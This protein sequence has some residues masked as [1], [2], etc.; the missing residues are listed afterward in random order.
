M[1]GS[2]LIPPL[3]LHGEE[4]SF[5]P[6]LVPTNDMVSSESVVLIKPGDSGV[7][8]GYQVDEFTCTWSAEWFVAHS[9][10][11]PWFT[12]KMSSLTHFSLEPGYEDYS[13]LDQSV[14]DFEQGLDSILTDSIKTLELDTSFDKPGTVTSSVSSGFLSSVSTISDAFKLQLDPSIRSCK[15]WSQ[16]W[17]P[18]A[19]VSLASK[20]SASKLI[21]CVPSHPAASRFQ[22]FTSPDNITLT[23]ANGRADQSLS[24]F[25]TGIGAAP[26]AT[27]DMEQFIS[28]LRV[29]LIDT[30]SPLPK[31]EGGF[32]P[33][34][35][36]YELP[37]KI[38]D[39]PDNVVSK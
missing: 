2:H 7:V 38:H 27:L 15:L 35:E 33:V 10:I 22:S 28:H 23:P 14:T 32:M 37:I 4:V 13:F 12:D 26:H 6:G 17:V 18:V 5:F 11:Y 25:Q 9:H 16:A 24:E 31:S 3:S 36:V 8:I 19:P 29:A 39:I 1:A 34:S 21:H 30:I 20:M